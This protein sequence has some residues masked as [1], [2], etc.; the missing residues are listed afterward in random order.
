MTSK[1]RFGVTGSN[2][3]GS[4]VYT[5]KQIV[6][7]FKKDLKKISVHMWNARHAD[8]TFWLDQRFRPKSAGK[9]PRRR[10]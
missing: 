4:G 5:P 3:I 9:A 6:A 10:A 2:M 1:N 8:G 7:S